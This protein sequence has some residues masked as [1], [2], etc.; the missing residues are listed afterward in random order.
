MKK[1]LKILA[2]ARALSILRDEG[3]KKESVTVVAG[4]AGG[5]KWL[6]LNGLDRALFSS[7]LDFSPHPVF[8]IGSSIGAWRFAAIAQGMGSG[9]Y[10]RFEQAYL[11][12]RY[13]DWPTAAEVSRGTVRVME[14]YLDQ[15]GAR[16]VL[17]HPFFRLSMLAVRC[18]GLLSRDERYALGPAMLLAGLVNGMSRTALKLFFSRTLLFDP[19]SRPPLFAKQDGLQRVPLTPENMG[20]ALL[21]SGS[22]PL[23]MEGVRDLDGAAPGMY[24][25]GGLLDYHLDIPFGDDGIVLFP[26]YTDSIIPGWLDKMLP[27]RKPDRDNIRHVVL[28]C[29]SEDFIARLPHRKIP[30]RDDFILFRGSDRER[31]A[32][33]EKVVAASSIL[34]EEFL[35]L[36]QSGAIGRE[37]ALLE[38]A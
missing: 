14:A 19:R 18:R 20:S 26:H 22:I 12:Q 1:N 6:V 21:A 17:D 27:W 31:V 30:D 10:D 9:A 2:G 11:A 34:G 37:A 13:S 8:L 4:A 23:V 29:P 38:G 15:A 32:Y 33:W 25:D 16:A 35:E 28:V 36:V 7:W 3:L 24:R 5:P